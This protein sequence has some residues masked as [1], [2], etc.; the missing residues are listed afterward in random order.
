M[1]GIVANSAV[2][3]MEALFFITSTLQWGQLCIN[4]DKRRALTNHKLRAPFTHITGID[5]LHAAERLI[6]P[7]YL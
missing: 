3:N 2:G 6:N 1:N 5:P 4:G 7:E